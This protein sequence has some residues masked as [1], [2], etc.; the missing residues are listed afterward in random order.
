MS[1]SPK[2]EIL[3]TC[4]INFKWKLIL[5]KKTWDFPNQEVFYEKKHMG[6]NNFLKISRTPSLTCEYLPKKCASNSQQRRHFISSFLLS[7][8]W[9]FYFIEF[10]RINNKWKRYW[11]KIIIFLCQSC[12]NYIYSK[13]TSQSICWQPSS[14]STA[15]RML[16]ILD[17]S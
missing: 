2:I 11:K 16:W 13:L 7:F 9:F 4:E 17:L 1:N 6:E 15:S 10:V 8:K 3:K 14:M 12:S 5:L